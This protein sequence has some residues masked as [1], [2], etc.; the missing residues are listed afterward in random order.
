[1]L[2]E[3]GQQDILPWQW[4]KRLQRPSLC[5]SIQTHHSVR[6]S[7]HLLLGKQTHLKHE[8]IVCGNRLC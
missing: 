7:V 8:L 4:R 6:I 3:I 1:M 5:Q 2:M